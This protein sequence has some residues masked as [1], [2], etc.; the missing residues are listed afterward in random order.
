MN[1]KKIVVEI[2]GWVGV[3]S[4]VGAYALVSY[5]IISPDQLAY[6]LI[7]LLGAIG[8]IINSWSKKDYQPVVLNVV[9]LI[10][11]LTAIFTVIW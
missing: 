4:I 10:I 1:T 2:V 9:W 5:G 11:A 7:N 3:A 8:I 6:Q